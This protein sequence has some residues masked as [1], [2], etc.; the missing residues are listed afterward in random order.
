[1]TLPGDG[2]PVEPLDRLV[3]PADSVEETRRRHQSNRD[4]W[5]EGAAYY[6]ARVDETIA[7]IRAGQSNL[8][9]LER[10]ML[11]PLQEWCDTA[12]HLQCA[13]G[14]DTLSLW[15]EGAR[16]VVGLDISDVM[17]ENARRTADALGAPA[18]W[19]RCDVLEAPGDLDGTADLVY[20]GRGALNWVQDIGGWAAVVARMLKPGGVVSIFDEHPTAWL[21]R[22]DT[23]ELEVEPG[24]DYFRTAWETQGWSAEYIGVLDRPAAELAVKYDR[25]WPLGDIFGALSAAGLVVEQL[26]EHA[27]SYW[28]AFPRLAE[29]YR[30]RIP[31]TFTMLARKPRPGGTPGGLRP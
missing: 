27:E 2:S 6:T 8:H 14:R 17:I 1:M 26:G 30:G 7:F 15:V 13:S 16:Q 23:E 31:Q 5:N 11:G 4:A 9:P 18:R 24:V 19:V 12:I 21:F 22:V 20:T 3:A 28:N 29:V 10:A 25:M